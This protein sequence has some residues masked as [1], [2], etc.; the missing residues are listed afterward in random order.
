MKKFSTNT[1]YKIYAENGGTLS[2]SV[3]YKLVNEYHKAMVDECIKGYKWSLPFNLGL[4][5]IVMSKR[6]YT[7]LPDGA[8]RGSVDWGKSNKLKA[9][10]LEKGQV[11]LKVFKDEEGNK[12]GDNGGVAW[13]CYFTDSF[14]YCWTHIT[15]I[16]LMN[17][18]KYGF[19]F[20]WSNSR[21]LSASITKDSE[22]LYEKR[23]D[24]SVKDYLKSKLDT[25]HRDKV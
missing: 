20:S 6:K 13:L 17:A 8:I 15:N 14:Y 19:D 21:K 18:T 11:P 12:I 25:V 24:G 22:F 10:I 16:Y 3:F 1:L 23:K 7:V 2:Y 4:I 9:E 5:K